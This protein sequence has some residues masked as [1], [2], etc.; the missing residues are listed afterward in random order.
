MS[1][2]PGH[3]VI[4]PGV[5]VIAEEPKTIGGAAGLGGMEFIKEAEANLAPLGIK[6][7]PLLTAEAIRDHFPEDLRGDLASFEGKKGYV[8]TLHQL[9]SLSLPLTDWL[10]LCA[11]SLTLLEDGQRLSVPSRSGC[12]WSSSSEDRLGPGWRWMGW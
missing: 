1:D 4:Y 3:S 11:R 8:R 9:L 10:P 5:V 7:T 2:S 6:P 12:R